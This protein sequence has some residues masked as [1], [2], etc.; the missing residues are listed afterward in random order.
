MERKKMKMKVKREKKKNHKN[1]GLSCLRHPVGLG[2]VVSFPFSFCWLYVVRVAQAS[3]LLTM[4]V[5]FSGT[6][7]CHE[8]PDI[9]YM[10]YSL[11]DDLFGILTDIRREE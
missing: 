8:Y 5:I 7:F 2:R 9:N 11:Q 1:R 3:G 10:Y 4:R 6:V